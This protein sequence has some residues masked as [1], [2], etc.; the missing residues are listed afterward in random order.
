[1]ALDPRLLLSFVVLAEELH[2]GRAAVRLHIAQSGLSVQIRRLE[3]QVG[4]PLYT[5]SSRNVE[6]TPVGRAM[7]EP[8]RAAIRAAEQAEH[9][10]REAA[11]ESR[12]L[13]RVGVDLFLEDVIPTVDCYALEHPELM[14]FMPRM[15]EPLGRAML[16]AGQI[17]AFVGFQPRT[18]EP[19]MR[20][21]HFMNVPLHAT[22]GPDTPL[23]T[24]AS[25]SLREFRESTI[26]CVSRRVDLRAFDRLMDVLSEGRGPETLTLLEIDATGSASNVEIAIEIAAGR[27]VGVNTPATIAVHAKQLR[28]IPF[29]PPILLPSSITWSAGRSPVLD[30]FS[31]A[32]SAFAPA[33]SGMARFTGT[34]PTQTLAASTAN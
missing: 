18:D 21:V 17:D 12:H 10:A 6:L 8:A 3:E 30:A 23:A 4:A 16:K 13:L 28:S 22:V 34:A 11:R 15:N 14:I 27:A 9:A 33:T 7:L 5:R 32:L 2:F 1:M 20:S 29:D 24:S 31:E 26:A 19:D 25:I